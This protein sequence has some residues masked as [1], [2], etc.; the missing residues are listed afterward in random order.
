MCKH[1]KFKKEYECDSFRIKY[2]D[3]RELFSNTIE[4]DGYI[5]AFY[6]GNK[7]LT[8]SVYFL[9]VEQARVI[10]EIKMV[11]FHLITGLSG[12]G[13]WKRQKA[14]EYSKFK[15]DDSL[16]LELFNQAESIRTKSNKIEESIL[17]IS[18]D[19]LLSVNIVEMF[20]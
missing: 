19:D 14:E 13:G 12:E 16:L 5:H 7:R 18:Y 20:K 6:S 4:K 1:V 17:K 10:S 2:P 9:E 15:G 11:A 3:S 8:K